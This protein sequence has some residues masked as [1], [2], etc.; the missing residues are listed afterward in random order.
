MSLSSKEA[1][2]TL[3]DVERTAQR[4]AQAFSYRNTS[5][6]LILWGV[7][8]LIGYAGTD[9]RPAYWHEIWLVLIVSA[10]VIAMV[11]GHGIRGR[12][13]TANSWRVLGLM[14]VVST[15]IAATCAI[16]W[17]V[18]GMQFGAFA[19]LLTGAV[20]AGLGLW[21]GTRYVMLGVSIIALTLVSYFYLPG[22]FLL[23]MAAV[24]GGGMILAGFWFRTV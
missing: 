5:P 11:L 21:V 13:D 17:P 6:H 4:S 9:L 15:F 14:A 16:M 7:V 20:Y 3:S 18:S 10:I 24:G 8:W 22:H 12:S 19:P 23:C 1:A 2:E